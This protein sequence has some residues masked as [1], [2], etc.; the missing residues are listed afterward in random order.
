MPPVLVRPYV[1]A[2][3][4]T[5]VAPA[6]QG[7]SF[8]PPP[9]TAPPDYRPRHST[10]GD[11][12]APAPAQPARP[13]RPAGAARAV[14]AVRP[15]RPGRPAGPAHAVATVRADGPARPAGARHLAQPARS[16]R[17]AHA[18]RPKRRRTPALAW[19]ALLITLAATGL[20]MRAGELGEGTLTA[21]EAG[22]LQMAIVPAPTAAPAVPSRDREAKRLPDA[23]VRPAR[24]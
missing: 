24:S 23:P 12:V 11:P 1:R 8:V 7:R 19:G 6:H 2:I 4:I 9:R 14:V 17:S 16:G 18:V 15:V 10:A 5:H 13:T 20:S 3:P 22:R 21:A